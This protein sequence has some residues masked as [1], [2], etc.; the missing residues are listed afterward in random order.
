MREQK[1]A[2]GV[3]AS[4]ERELAVVPLDTLALQRAADDLYRAVF[5]Y[6]D[7]AYALSPRLLR[8]LLIN[9]GT[10]LGALDRDGTLLGFSYGYPGVDDG[11][12]YHYSQA[13]AVADR[14]QGTGVGRLLK[15]AQADLARQT[16]ATSMRW[17][18]DP[19]LTRNG[20]F[21]LDTLG[22]RGRWF[23]PDFYDEPES[24]RLVVDWALDGSGAV[25]DEV[26]AARRRALDEVDALRPDGLTASGVSGDYRWLLLP[27]ELPGDDA[28]RIAVREAV[29]AACG[30][31]L[32]SG[33]SALSC[34]G[35]ATM[36]RSAVYLFGGDAA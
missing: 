19:A 32:D 21:N 7:S 3:G 36:P 11:R 30:S 28:A 18:Y 6:V 4:P 8:G 12:I 1:F 10:A 24:D 2:P 9:G 16:G 33:S 22:A 5:G 25:S 35:S 23:H 26:G 14:A 13:T 34:R 27:R 29:A 20:H 15:Y 31:A 17:A